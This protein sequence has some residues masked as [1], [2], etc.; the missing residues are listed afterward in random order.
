MWLISVDNDNKCESKSVS[1][2]LI[3]M[4]CVTQSVDIDDKCDSKV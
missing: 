2:I 3:I 4:I 1:T